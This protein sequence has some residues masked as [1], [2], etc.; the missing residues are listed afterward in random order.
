MQYNRADDHG[1]KTLLIS[2]V[3]LGD[4]YYAN[5]TELQRCRRP[6]IR[7]TGLAFDS[8]VA[9][10]SSTQTHR[11]FVLYDH[12]QAYPEYIVSYRE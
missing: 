8:V 6:P 7:G 9:N 4:P 2:R 11:E 10:S 3:A 12:R 5:S 1:V